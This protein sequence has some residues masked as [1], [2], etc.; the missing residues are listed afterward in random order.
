MG[1]SQVERNRRLGRPGS[2]GRG[3]GGR[4]ATS[5][6]RGGGRSSTDGR[7]HPAP[8]LGS[9]EWRYA[10][11]ETN[12]ALG[13]IDD[14]VDAILGLTYG[15]S[16]HGAAHDDV[17]SALIGEGELSVDDGENSGGGGNINLDDLAKVLRKI[18]THQLLDMPPHIARE[19]DKKYGAL[20][21]E[22][23]AKTISELRA[24]A[25]SNNIQPKLGSNAEDEMV[26]KGTPDA[27]STTKDD[28]SDKK[29]A[30]ASGGD[31]PEA[32]ACVEE[33]IGGEEAEDDLDAW[34][35]SVI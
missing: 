34:L 19:Y 22:K 20:V 27:T 11:Q 12:T 28:A 32:S 15:Y 30:E 24:A 6:G 29:P 33:K 35:D 2:K 16:E 26:I 25:T 7:H 4:S 17:S 8:N 23:R 18:P 9:N 13:G 5:G 31:V 1:R 10:Q 3:G 14:D 21:D